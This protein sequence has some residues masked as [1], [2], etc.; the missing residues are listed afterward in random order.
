MKNMKYHSSSNSE[1]VPVLEKKRGAVE[2]SCRLAE[3][4]VIINVYD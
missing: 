1:R 4:L 3:I 2:F